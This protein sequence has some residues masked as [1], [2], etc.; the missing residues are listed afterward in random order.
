MNRL[1]TNFLAN[2]SHEL[3]TPLIG[4]LGYAELLA[5]ELKDKDLIEMAK[6]IGTSGERLNSTLNNILNISKIES[7]RQQNNFKMYDLIKIVKGQINLFKAAAEGKNL[8]LT[9]ETEEEKLDAFVDENMFISII[10]NLLNN[11][12]KYTEIG[13]IILNAKREKEYAIINVTDTGIGIAEDSH[14]IIFDPFRQASEGYSRSFEGTGLGLTLVKKYMDFM[15][16]T[17][18]LKSEPGNGSTF[19]IKLPIHKN[20]P[21]ILIKTNWS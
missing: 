15:N 20:I 11:A 1:K 8:L 4:I 14:E 17:I 5:G 13:A 18:I 12:I 21:E 7:E 10:N 16:G 19:I 9:L 3:R 2:M 6:A